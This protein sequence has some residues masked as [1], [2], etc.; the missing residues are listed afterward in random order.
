M[1]EDKDIPREQ[2]TEL[3]GPSANVAVPIGSTIRF[4]KRGQPERSGE[5]LQVIPAGTTAGRAHG[6][7]LV[8]DV[9][10]GEMPVYVKL[11]EVVM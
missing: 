4:K 9:G 5:L 10:G 3:F 7:L 11:D 2:L 1:S 6:M 8:V